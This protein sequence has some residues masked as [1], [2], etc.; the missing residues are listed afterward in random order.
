MTA[1]SPLFLLNHLWQSTAAA[2]AVLGL[3]LL[4]ASLSARTRRAL[5]WMALVKFALPLGALA[6]WLAPFG[7]DAPQRWLA[8]PVLTLP[9]NFA[10]AT[11]TT[12][13]SSPALVHASTAVPPV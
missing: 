5:G 9:G 13:S 8:A 3:L 6:A 11:V 10:P 12:P 2:L 7:G 4:S 1:P